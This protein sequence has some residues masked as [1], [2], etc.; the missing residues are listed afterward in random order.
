MPTFS[1]LQRN[2]AYKK[3]LINILL[4]ILV[5]LL[6]STYILIPLFIGIAATYKFNFFYVFIFLYLTEITH[7]YPI[8]SLL[9]FILIYKKYIYPILEHIINYKYIH[10]FSISFVYFI[11]FLFLDS[12]Y[13]YNSLA[14]DFSIY[15]I[16][17]YIAIEILISSFYTQKQSSDDE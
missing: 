6:N 4:I 1:E 2:F 10:Y 12:Y 5:I 15:Y 13:V 11:Y 3:H 7:N 16:L 9:I 14:F 8:F 17:L